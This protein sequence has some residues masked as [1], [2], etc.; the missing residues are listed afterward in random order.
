MSEIPNPDSLN[1][2]AE[3]LKAIRRLRETSKFKLSQLDNSIQRFTS[4]FDQQK[5]SLTELYDTTQKHQRYLTNVIT[6]RDSLQHTLDLVTTGKR[7]GPT[8]YKDID[9][10][11]EE[12]IAAMD[13]INKA[14]DMLS[15]LNFEDGRKAKSNLTLLQDVGRKSLLTYFMSLNEKYN[16]GFP[17]T[18]FSFDN[19]KN[20]VIRNEDLNKNITYP[21]TD[22][23]FRKMGEVVR[24]LKDLFDKDYLVKYAEARRQFLED[25]LRKLIKATKTRTTLSGNI[26]PLLIPS[27]FYHSHPI[28]MLLLT[29]NF[30]VDR[31][32]EMAHKIFINQVDFICV[33]NMLLSE[34]LTEIIDIIK[35]NCYQ[36]LNQHVDCLF[37]LDLAQTLQTI[38]PTFD[39]Y[40]EGNQ[41]MQQENFKKII[42]PFYSTIK[43]TFENLNSAIEKHDPAFLPFDGGVSPL[44]SNVLLFL[45]HLFPYESVLNVISTTEK[46]VTKAIH[47]L[48]A[49]IESKASHYSDQVLTQL[50][51]M[52]NFH[53]VYTT[54][55]SSKLA[56]AIS[57]ENKSRIE[58]KIQRAQEEYIKLTWDTAFSKLNVDNIG[59]IDAKTGLNKK[60][61]YIVKMAF[62]NFRDRIDELRQKHQGYNTK[63]AKLMSTIMNDTLR[64][65]SQ[66]YE[67]FWSKWKQSGF[68]KTP[69]K[70][71]CYQPSTLS[72][73]VTKLYTPSK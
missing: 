16:K 72:Q 52:N 28:H 18:Y 21:I 70:W 19:D 2:P 12:Y 34:T 41:K 47:S 66:K 11:F 15:T 62:K 20:F 67:K 56:D 35:K 59:D 40:V 3:Q 29:F 38:V 30:L 63:N 13:E 17:Q 27:Y 61:R 53:F 46:I 25:S 71:I 55:Q 51:I 8:I 33:M 43:S 64:K 5:E 6:T 44:T 73:M 39:K 48:A 50:F 60:Q 57:P 4:R 1:D 23:D 9:T 26:D 42:A 49:N 24:V 58:D 31:E 36:T 22:D 45:I 69:E 54:I 7:L 10:N 14:L 32:T 65:V 37:D 68:S